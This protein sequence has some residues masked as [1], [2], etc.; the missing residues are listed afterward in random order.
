MY[1]LTH[2]TPY[3]ALWKCDNGVT[4]TCARAAKGWP[5]MED[6]TTLCRRLFYFPSGH[7]TLELHKS[8]KLAAEAAD[9]NAKTISIAWLL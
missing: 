7:Q 8:G 5:Q 3:P 9:W 4:S 1:C 6:V 2:D